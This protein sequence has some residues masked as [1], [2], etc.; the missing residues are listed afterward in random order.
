LEEWLSESEEHRVFYQRVKDEFRVSEIR[1]YLQT[2]SEEAWER[3]RKMTFGASFVHSSSFR[4]WLRY[5]AVVV[6]IVLAISLW[7]V[8]EE[9]SWQ[10]M[11]GE[12]RT[13]E[14]LLPVLTLDNGDRYYLT[15][16]EQAEI[17]VND[18][19]K[20]YKTHEGLVYD[21][22]SRAEEVR[23]NHIRVPRG[24]EYQV[25]LADGTK[26]WLNAASELTYPVVFRGSERKVFL[27]GEG[28]FEVPPDKERPF[29]VK[30][31][32]VELRVLGTAFNINTH[33]VKSVRT[34]LV[35]GAVELDCGGLQMVR[36]TP[37]D[38]VDFNRET[39]EVVSRQVDVAPY[40]SWKEG[41]FVFE[42]E[43]L[44]DIMNTLAL[45][46]DKEVFF[47]GLKNRGLHFSGHLRRYDSIETILS[48]ITEVTGV[49]F[50]MNKNI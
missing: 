41:Y 23:Y 7:Y 2:D 15:P 48:A 32:E 19:V 20:A 27:Q 16:E 17:E 47:A 9:G 5:A 49:E 33:G 36:M 21:T 34:V 30:T 26:V 10:A 1:S 50:L 14:E 35:R 37:G 38:L 25:V 43:T 8:W 13:G 28:Y 24:C 11:P 40:I 31:E 4:R 12:V 3:V 6:P 39:S 18:G 29:Y 45:W 44:E 46:Y 42:N 22:A